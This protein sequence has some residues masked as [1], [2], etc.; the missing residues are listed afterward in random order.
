MNQLP[1]T[2][3]SLGSTGLRLTEIAFGAASIGNLYRAATDDEASDAVERA[4]ERGIRYFDTAPHYGLG[5]SERRLGRALAGYPRHEYVISTK[6]GRLLTPNPQPTPRDTDGF[7]VPGDLLRVWDF[8]R[9]GVRRSL[10]DSLLRLGTDHVEIVYAHDPDQFRAGA[11]RDALEALA[12]LRA[13][14]VVR[15]IGVGTNSVDELSDLFRDGL[16]DVAML[17]GRYTLLENGGLRTVLEPA[18]AAGAGIVVVGVYNTGL[19]STAWPASDARYDYG[20]APPD[21][22]ARARQLAVVCERHGTTLPEAAIA[23][24]LLHPAVSSVAI[25]MRSAEQVDSNVGRYEHAVPNELW[26]DLV[27][28]QLIEP[29][30]AGLG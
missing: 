19:L 24:A 20:Q 3:R 12:E 25:G 4:Y 2:T 9:D 22:I 13:Q 15:A 21:L 11:A 28:A 27:D 1:L 5:L 10:D 8:S 29:A 18:L 16:L 26:A 14:G 7:D 30:A 6:V 23:F 17:A